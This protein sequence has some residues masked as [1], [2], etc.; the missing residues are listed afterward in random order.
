MSGGGGSN[1]FMVG[2]M[3]CGEGNV[4]SGSNFFVVI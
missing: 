2:G 3:S 1:K 4:P